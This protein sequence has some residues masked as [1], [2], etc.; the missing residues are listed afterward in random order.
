MK[1]NMVLDSSFW[2]TNLTMKGVL[3]LVKKTF[4]MPFMTDFLN[5]WL[6]TLFDHKND[7]IVACTC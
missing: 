2:S 3:Q 5:E 4:F 1:E 7:V 6:Q